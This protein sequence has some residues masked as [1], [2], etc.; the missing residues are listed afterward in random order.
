MNPRSEGLSIASDSLDSSQFR[1]DGVIDIAVDSPFSQAVNRIIQ[2]NIESHEFPGTYQPNTIRAIARRDP[3]LFSG[4][5]SN[6][7]TISPSSRIINAWG[8]KS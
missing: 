7:V 1:M 4:F 6:S 2:S 8:I 3:N 5:L